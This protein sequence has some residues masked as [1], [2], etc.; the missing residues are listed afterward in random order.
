MASPKEKQLKSNIGEW[1]DHCPS[2]YLEGIDPHNCKLKNTIFNKTQPREKDPVQM[3]NVSLS[4]TNRQG[5]PCW[6]AGYS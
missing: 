5:Q 1:L 4:L 6:S 2:W 3:Q